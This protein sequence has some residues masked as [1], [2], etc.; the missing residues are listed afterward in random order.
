MTVSLYRSVAIGGIFVLLFLSAC[1]GQP[2]QTSS[3]DTSANEPVQPL[4]V[5]SIP[6][7]DPERVQRLADSLATYLEAELEI[8]VDYQPVTNY[9][10]AVTA[11]RGGGSGPSLV[12]RAYRC[13]SSAAGGRS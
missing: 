4:I 1:G 3:E 9:A 7:Q 10:A 12:W 6:D 2:S 11:F 5:G 13:A 8:P